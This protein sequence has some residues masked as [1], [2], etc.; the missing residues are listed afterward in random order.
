MSLV[1]LVCLLSKVNQH[2]RNLNGMLDCCGYRKELIKFS[3][4][5]FL[6]FV[7]RTDLWGLI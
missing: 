7:I 6:A 2:P 5:S 1:C 3:C 4:D